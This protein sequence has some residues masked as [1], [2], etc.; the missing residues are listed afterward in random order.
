MNL[1]IQIIGYLIRSIEIVSSNRQAL[2]MRKC[3][4]RLN[5]T[6]IIAFFCCCN[7]ASAREPQAIDGRI[8]LTDWSTSEPLKLAGDWFFFPNQHISPSDL[9]R[10]LNNGS[11]KSLPISQTF[12][13]LAPDS[14]NDN[15]G[16]ASY[17]LILDGLSAQESL[18][19]MS[20]EIYTSGAVYIFAED[21]AEHA[22]A[23]LTIGKPGLSFAETEAQLSTRDYAIIHPNGQRLYLL[24]Q[25]SNFHNLAWGGMWIPPQIGAIKS[26]IA[27]RATQ[28]NSNY[29]MIGLVLFI[30][31]YNLSLYLR[32]REDKGSLYLSILCFFFIARAFVYLGLTEKI[33]PS[34]WSL[35]VTYKIVLISMLCLPLT[36]L[37]FLGAYFPKEVSSNLLRILSLFTAVIVTAIFFA[38]APYYGYFGAPLIYI[39]LA[40]M[41]FIFFATCRA[42]L[43]RRTGASMAMIGA[44]GLAIGA[45]I[46]ALYAWGWT[47]LPVNSLVYGMIFFTFFQSQIVAK[48][49]VHAFRQSEHL[50]R[51]LRKEVD[52]QTRDIKSILDSMKQGVFTVMAPGRAIGSQYSPY[53]TQVI[54]RDIHAGMSLDELL[55]DRTDL[56]SDQ[57]NQIHAALEASLEEDLIGFETNSHCLIAET[58]YRPR[59]DAEAHIL[60]LDWAPIVDEQEQVEKVLIC[61]RD[62]T[63]IRN[64]RQEA[65]RNQRDIQILQELIR[66]PEDRFHRFLNKSK[67]YLNENFKYLEENNFNDT[68]TIKR[69]FVNLHTLKGTARTY[70]FKDISAITHEAEH[71]LSRIL[72]GQIPI[73]ID[74]LF[75]DHNKVAAVLQYYQDIAKDKLSW[76]LDERIIKLRK[77]SISE[78]IP[79]IESLR[80]ESLSKEGEK[81]LGLIATRLIESCN[82]RLTDVIDEALRGMD[83][84]ARD[85]G[86]LMPEV[87][88]GPNQITLIDAWSD[89]FHSALTHILR[90]SIDHGIER[91]EERL[92]QS[93]R[94]QGQILIGIEVKNYNLTIDIRDDGAGLNLTRIASIAVEKGLTK[95]TDDL[96]DQQIADFIFQSGFSTKNSVTD[97]SGRGV[98][99]DAVRSFLEPYEGQVNLVLD[100]DTG[101][102]HHVPFAIC[103]VLPAAAWWTSPLQNE[104]L[105][106][107][108]HS[109]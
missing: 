3:M 27:N 82:A 37:Y 42:S 71:E 90:N 1:A 49:F 84:I 10:S 50:S 52:R 95:S 57:K 61:V 18:A 41:G 80:S 13:Q 33:V 63:E 79:H 54:G 88:I 8:D 67:D 77:D 22:Q 55:L 39:S 68:Q 89:R 91:P 43:A 36:G 69:L 103:I 100:D 25:I 104:E 21:Q 46:E 56:S 73:S 53:L 74:Q 58:T 44:C 75:A 30:A 5:M 83:S 19:M 9:L 85:L 45:C 20:P 65:D 34:S 38:P 29:L 23:A 62:V 17:A 47:F 98:G 24:I 81:H 106:H 96:N 51:E 4:L 12:A 11:F 6:L 14:Y 40:F 86:K 97:I 48:L 70:Q 28:E 16:I 87:I 102:R 109:A 31:F 72:K 94:E 76:S 7:E 107:P 35:P 93:K 59:E 26:L 101:D 15:I 105:V 32:R 78:L 99:M 60:E 108:R 66:I 64:L 2:M 92:L